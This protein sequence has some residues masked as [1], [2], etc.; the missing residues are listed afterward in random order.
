MFM[1]GHEK[2]L[3]RW[4]NYLLRSIKSPER[5]VYYNKDVHQQT[6]SSQHS[7]SNSLA[8]VPKHKY[9]ELTENLLDTMLAFVH[10]KNDSLWDLIYEDKE[11]DIKVY[12]NDEIS[13]CCYKITS[14][15]ENTPQ[16]TFDL[17]ADVRRR[18]EW[19]HMTA[20]AGI[21]E[22]IDESTRVQYVK[23]KAVFPTSARDVVTIGYTTQLEDGRMV[24][25]NRSIEH[26]LCPEKPGIVRIEAGCAGVVVEPIKDQPNKC[27]VTQIADANPKGWIPKSVISLV[28]TRDMPTSV[29]KLNRLLA[30]MPYQSVSKILSHT[31]FIPKVPTRPL[32]PISSSSSSSSLYQFHRKLDSS[33][34]EEPLVQ[35]GSETDKS[36]ESLSNESENHNNDR[37]INRF[38]TSAF[39]LTFIQTILFTGGNSY[40]GGV[41]PISGGSKKSNGVSS[42]GRFVIA[43]A[44]YTLVLI[45]GIRKWR[46]RNVI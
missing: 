5:Q 30:K 20:E 27:H 11:A 15:M 43:A 17:L 37:S 4:R 2:L 45:A 18:P 21:V 46:N 19:D 10:T 26:R 24:M 6:S 7:A 22:I 29:K 36:V 42:T 25:V 9:S 38:S 40:F 31:P 35:D 41:V 8:S 28:S 32:T 39:W 34:S 33:I 1:E 23:M 44:A 16:T 13:S 14:T 12:K 3:V